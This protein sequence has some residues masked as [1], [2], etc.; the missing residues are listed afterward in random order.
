M[1]VVTPRTDLLQKVH[2]VKTRLNWNLG[3]P[4]EKER[5][6]RFFISVVMDLHKEFGR[7]NLSSNY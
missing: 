7:L 5:R 3:F 2:A 6:K 4:K 1:G